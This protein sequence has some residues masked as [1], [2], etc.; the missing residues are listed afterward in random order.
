MFLSVFTL[1]SNAFGGNELL[2]NIREDFDI[3]DTRIITAYYKNTDIK[4]HGVVNEK[5]DSDGYYNGNTISANIYW[6]F[7]GDICV[8]GFRVNGSGVMI[9]NSNTSKLMLLGRQFNQHNNIVKAYEAFVSQNGNGNAP[10]PTWE[11]MT[12]CIYNI[13]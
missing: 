11:Q 7:I 10:K 5:Y 8:S 3:T 4:L 12:E 9:Y 6:T 13:K 2:I 1:F